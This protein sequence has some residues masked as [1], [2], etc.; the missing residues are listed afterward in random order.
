MEWPAVFLVFLVSHLVGDWILQT[1]WQ[2]T[3]KPLGL[4]SNGIPRRALASHAAIY[5]LCFVP[6][7][8][9]LSDTLSAGEELLVAALI[10][11]PHYIQDDGRLIR[12][13]ARRV[14][15]LDSAV[16]PVVLLAVD[17]GFHVLALFAV[18]IAVGA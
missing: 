6:S 10:G 15:K 9:W 5:T 18:A 1:D 14:K 4:T 8:V 13:Y 3:N 2:A 17:Q 11:V 12:A 7:L 16:H